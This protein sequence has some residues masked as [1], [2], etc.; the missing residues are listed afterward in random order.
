MGLVVAKRDPASAMARALVDVARHAE[1]AATLD[2]L[3]G[4]TPAIDPT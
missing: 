2:R 4:R 1:T 3:P